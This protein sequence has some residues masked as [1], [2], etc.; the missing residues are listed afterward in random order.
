M[1]WNDNERN[2]IHFYRLALQLF[3]GDQTGLDERGAGL[4]HTPFQ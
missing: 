4:L 3:E 2:M 1:D